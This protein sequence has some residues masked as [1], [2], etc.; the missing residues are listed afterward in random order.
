M[1]FVTDR[2]SE[3]HTVHVGSNLLVERDKNTTENSWTREVAILFHTL[4]LQRGSRVGKSPI[5]ATAHTGSAMLQSQLTAYCKY[6]RI[7]EYLNGNIGTRTVWW[8][9]GFK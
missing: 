1:K 8:I 7:G 3:S 2:T 5:G 4:R 6:T 9:F